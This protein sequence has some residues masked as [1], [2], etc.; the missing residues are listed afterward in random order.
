[1]VSFN[2]HLNHHSSSIIRHPSFVI[3]HSIVCDPVMGDDG[4]M[5]VPQE[6]VAVYRDKLLPFAFMVTPNQTEAE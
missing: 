3:H 2:V 4:R 1:M 6:F 5:Y